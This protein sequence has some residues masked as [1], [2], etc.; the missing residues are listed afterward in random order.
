MKDRE[1]KIVVENLGN[2][3]PLP[4]DQKSYQKDTYM[5]LVA[6]WF[7]EHYHFINKSKY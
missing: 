6:L 3:Q 5:I 1:E 7:I 4:F 2:P